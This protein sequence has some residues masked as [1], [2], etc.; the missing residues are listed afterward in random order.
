M[1]GTEDLL[2]SSVL[3][4]VLLRLMMLS[5]S[6]AASYETKS[7]DPGLVVLTLPVPVTGPESLAFDARGGGPYSGVSDGRIL[8]WRGDLR[9]VA[10]AGLKFRRGQDC[11]QN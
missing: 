9:P 6:A 8:Q 1:K 7:I 11:K 10:D 4:V 5:A 3:A 2:P